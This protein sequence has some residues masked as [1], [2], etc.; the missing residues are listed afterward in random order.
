M[1]TKQRHI[2]TKAP[3]GTQRDM[4]LRL[5]RELGLVRPRDLEARGIARVY[6]QRLEAE[7]EVERL[8]RGLYAAHGASVTEHHS[9]AQAAKLVPRGVVCLISALS[10][11]GL[12]TQ[13][14][15]EVWI[16][17]GPHSRRP[18]VAYPPLR[19]VW[20]ARRPK[21]GIQAHVVDGVKVQVTAPA[22]TIIDCFRY[23]NKI[24][25]DVAL[26][27]LRDYLGTKKGTRDELWRTA[28]SSGAWRVLKPYVE[29]LSL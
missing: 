29:A 21:R 25:L 8:G 6:L 18:R 16:A 12:G 14:P 24:G 3:R 10:F 4:A 15:A 27:A 28:R 2:E 11:H 7:G 19:I 20:T 9:L 17:L 23:R 5:V 13:I 26:E 1:I 22:Q